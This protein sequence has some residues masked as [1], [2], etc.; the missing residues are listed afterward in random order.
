MQINHP[1][2]LFWPVKLN[3]SHHQ[4]KQRHPGTKG[5]LP[6]N[7]T[8][9]VELGDG[10]NFNWKCFLTSRW[11]TSFGSD[12]VMGV[13]L[14]CEMDR[15]RLLKYRGPHTLAFNKKRWKLW[16]P[17]L[18][19]KNFSEMFSL[20]VWAKESMNRNH[21][22]RLMINHNCWVGWFVVG[23]STAGME[24]NFC[25]FPQLG[26]HTRAVRTSVPSHHTLTSTYTIN[27]RTSFHV[28]SSLVKSRCVT[29]AGASWFTSASQL[30]HSA[31]LIPPGDHV[32]QN[33]RQNLVNS[34]FSVIQGRRTFQA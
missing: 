12:T 8:S 20:T 22:G 5:L 26:S 3:L 1:I 18:E 31:I 9:R 2:W 23:F 28:P 34:K 7:G 19:I 4:K 13:S 32:T 14:H 17:T 29:D 27:A 25:T 16:K 30:H 33:R 10:H 11:L 15:E 21:S 6:G 24:G